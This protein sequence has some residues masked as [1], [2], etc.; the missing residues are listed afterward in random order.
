M[1]RSPRVRVVNL[2][3]E[4]VHSFS[5]NCC[6]FI[7]TVRVSLRKFC[8]YRQRYICQFIELNNQHWL[9]FNYCLLKIRVPL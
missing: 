9:F 6:L 1:E 5:Y 4:K 3:M 8:K 2:G 7:V